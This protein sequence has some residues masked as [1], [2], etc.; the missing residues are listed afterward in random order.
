MCLSVKC[1]RLHMLIEALCPW[2]S[3]L[4]SLDL[5]FFKWKLKRTTLASLMSLESWGGANKMLDTEVFQSN[6]NE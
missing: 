6:L 1:L 2:S 4:N 5:C 3:P